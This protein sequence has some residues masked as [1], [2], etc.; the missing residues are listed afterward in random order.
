MP[1]DPNFILYGDKY[2]RAC[3]FRACVYVM[4]ANYCSECEALC[5]R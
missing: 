5:D 4:K 1:F 3:A 2:V